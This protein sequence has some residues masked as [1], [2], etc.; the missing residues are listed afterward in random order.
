MQQD[1]IKVKLPW[2]IA[3]HVFPISL[4]TEAD[5]KPVI[6]NVLEQRS[7]VET[8]AF[9]MALS[10]APIIRR[11][12]E[13]TLPTTAQ[14]GRG[15]EDDPISPITSPV[16]SLSVNMRSPIR[17]DKPAARS[18]AP[19]FAG[20]RA[21]V[22]RGRPPPL[23]GDL[24]SF[25][26]PQKLDPAPRP[27]EE[28]ARAPLPASERPTSPSRSDPPPE[29]HHPREENPSSPRSP[30]DRPSVTSAL[31]WTRT[32]SAASKFARIWPYQ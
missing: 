29:T 30:P 9:F 6:P 18:S 11:R 14:R 17:A 2:T 19:V 28:A 1:G 21:G 24:C 12:G 32:L 7:P 5:N 4:R 15:A 3:H 22:T 16:A 26:M 10:R 31:W 13:H 8:Q 20:D 25:A 23:A 27:S